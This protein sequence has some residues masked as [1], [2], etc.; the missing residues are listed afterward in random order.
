[1][2]NLCASKSARRSSCI[3]CR[4]IPL[5][6]H[7]SKLGTL[8]R[9]IVQHQQR[10]KSYVKRRLSVYT[11]QEP[12]SLTRTKAKWASLFGGEREGGDSFRLSS[13]SHLFFK[14]KQSE[15]ERQQQ[16]QG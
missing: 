14:S 16:Q 13:L 2:R 3:L 1:M 10:G 12:F 7:K 8:Y 9:S 15:D 5:A 6:S 4:P 11:T